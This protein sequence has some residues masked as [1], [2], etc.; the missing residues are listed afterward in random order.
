MRARSFLLASTVV[1]AFS[2][3]VATSARADVVK[4]L[5]AELPADAAA[6]AVENLAGKMRVSV[7]D[8]AGVAVTATVY[9]E[10]EELAG[11]VRIEQV[12]GEHGP[13]LRVRYPYDRVHTFRYRDPESGWEGGLLGLASSSSYSYD[14]RTV[15]VN[16][17]RG[18][19]LYAD[20]EVVV[21][22]R[23]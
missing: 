5:H 17:G 6:F 11:A 4:T 1:C 2:S 14:G 15:H 13:T 18:T 7:G 9:A 22:R 19:R 8:Q 16:P 12:S 21:P 10:T 20:L 3:S 23:E